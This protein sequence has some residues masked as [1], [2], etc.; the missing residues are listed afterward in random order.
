MRNPNIQCEICDKP[1][2]RR[3]SELEKVK[4][5]CCKGCR[6]KLYK[7]YKCYNS[8][9]LE[10][11]R[12]WNKG[13]SKAKGDILRYG[14]PRSIKT[15]ELISKKLKEVLIRTGEFKTCSVCGKKR[16]VFPSD[17]KRGK[18][19]FCSKRCAAIANN[20]IQKNSDTDIERILEKW[21][22]TNDIVFEKQK[23]IDGITIPDFFIKPNICLY[24]DGDYWHNLPKVKTRDSWINKQLEKKNYQIIRLWGSDIKNGVRPDVLL[25]K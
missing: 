1:L 9:G 19:N 24:A 13:M 8:S 20:L 17:I 5:V 25:Q 6:S 15:R 2:Y 16:Y 3:P 21:L 10:K 18:G 7:K 11:G 22:T 4:H 12:G 23:P 14:R